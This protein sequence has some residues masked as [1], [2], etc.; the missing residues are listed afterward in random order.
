MTEEEIIQ[1]ARDLLVSTTPSNYACAEVESA[2]ARADAFA[3]EIVKREAKREAE[4]K[5]KMDRCASKAADTIRASVGRQCVTA[6]SGR[7]FFV[8]RDGLGTLRAEPVSASDVRLVGCPVVD[9]DGWLFVV[10]SDVRQER[11]VHTRALP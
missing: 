9:R 4:V 10:C 1:L 2:F 5:A 3:A 7:L 8:E 11:I 6:E